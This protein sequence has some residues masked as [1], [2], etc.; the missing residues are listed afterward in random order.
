MILRMHKAEKGKTSKAAVAHLHIC[1]S[2]TEHQ[3]RC[4]ADSLGSIH[5][6]AFAYS[7]QGTTG[8]RSKLKK[9]KPLPYQRRKIHKVPDHHSAPPGFR[10]HATSHHPCSSG[11]SAESVRSRATFTYVAQL[12]IHDNPLTGVPIKSLVDRRPG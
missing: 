3:I 8:Y 12:H 7:A 4:L 6:I 1:T 9:T 5:D 10:T 11:I 2:R